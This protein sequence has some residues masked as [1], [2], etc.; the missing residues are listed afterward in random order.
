MEIAVLFEKSLV[1]K[2]Q[3]VIAWNKPAENLTQTAYKIAEVAGLVFLTLG[4]FFVDAVVAAPQYICQFFAQ[5][6][7]FSDRQFLS[8]A[9]SQSLQAMSPEEQTAFRRMLAAPDQ[10]GH[11]FNPYR[12]AASCAIAQYLSISAPLS[13][14]QIREGGRPQFLIPC[15]TLDGLLLRYKAVCSTHPQDQAA[16]LQKA[17]APLQNPEMGEF[18]RKVVRDIDFLAQTVGVQKTFQNELFPQ[19]GEV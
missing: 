1:V 16:I 10:E 6:P 8:E 3:L 11:P 14:A 5:K 17:R 13:P 19:I 15:Q 18:S 12:W 9:L 4:H 7:V 2:G